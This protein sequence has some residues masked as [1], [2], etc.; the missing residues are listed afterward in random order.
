MAARRGASAES[1]LPAAMIPVVVAML[2]AP[3][4]FAPIDVMVAAGFN[5]N[6]WHPDINFGARGRC[7]RETGCAKSNT[8]SKKK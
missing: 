1:R 8:G 2:V 3:D 4:R 7:V 5:G 6:T